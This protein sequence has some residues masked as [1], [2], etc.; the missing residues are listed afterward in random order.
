MRAVL[1]AAA[2]AFFLLP[3]SAHAGADASGWQFGASR[4][5]PPKHRAARHRVKVAKAHRKVKPVRA[6]AKRKPAV[7]ATVAA[8]V[9]PS[10]PNC[11][12]G[13]GAL[14][15]LV[16]ELRDKAKAIVEKCMG[17]RVTSAVAPRPYRS[18]HPRHRAVDL[19]GNPECIYPMLKDWPGGYS[20]DYH[21]AP[22]GPHVHISYNPNGQEW[23]VR[24]AH[25]HYG[26]GARYA[27]RRVRVKVARR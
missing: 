20:T 13:V 8:V 23:G 7:I 26:A 10:G 21:T 3:S 5:V 15:C 6:V 1:I 4:E 24:F 27:T 22:G 19:A 17:V 9:L 11:R 18:N 16:P 12:S 2:A 25:S 14:D